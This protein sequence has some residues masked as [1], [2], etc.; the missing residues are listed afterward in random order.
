MKRAL[1]TG[2]SGFIGSHCLVPLVDRGYEVHAVWSRGEPLEVEGVVWHRADLLDESQLSILVSTVK[3]T[4]LLHLAWFVAHGKYLAAVEN[5]HWTQTSLSLFRHFGAHG[6]QRA[7]TAGS[8]YEYDWSYGYCSE[9]LTPLAR[10]TVYGACKS[11]LHELVEAYAGAT[12]FSSAWARIFFLYGP[13]EHPDRLVSS[14][15]RH[16]LVEE[17][18]KCS[19]GEQIRDYLHVQDVGD[20]LVSLLDS[21]VS[22]SVNIG[23]GKP[24]LLKEIVATI[25]HKLGRPDLIQL[26]GIPQRV[27]DPPLVVA[28]VTR[29]KSELG[30]KPAYDLH[31][32]LDHTIRWWSHRLAQAS[33]GSR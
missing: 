21:E 1:V 2:A 6:G 20:A 9:P 32:G 26:G 17:P 16:L 11:A 7:V 25:G 23:S 3:P 30:W 28:D 8:S 10:D 18:A 33:G 14:V 24:I 29:L 4:H 13:R 19:H 15:I 27:Y 22:G 12:G 5:F 31:T